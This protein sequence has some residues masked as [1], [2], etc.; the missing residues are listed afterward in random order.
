MQGRQKRRYGSGIASVS[1]AETSPLTVGVVTMARI[2]AAISSSAS[3]LAMPAAFSGFA[4]S[5]M[6]L[7]ASASEKGSTAAAT[8]PISARR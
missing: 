8:C 1:R 2:R 7:P 5:K 4:A 3:R 6:R